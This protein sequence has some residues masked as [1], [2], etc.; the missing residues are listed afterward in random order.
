MSYIIVNRLNRRKDND[1]WSIINAIGWSKKTTNYEDIK[2][3]L[4]DTLSSREFKKF[5]KDVYRLIKNVKTIAIDA[6]SKYK[7]DNIFRDSD[8]G[9]SDATA[10]IVGLGKTSYDDFM[11]HPL[12]YVAK[13]TEEHG[14]R[15]W[16]KENFTYIFNPD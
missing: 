12:I 13:K 6:H 7:I 15:F 9:W 3:S 2:L 10:H 16:A 4:K 5:E 8:D 14:D 1:V 11:A